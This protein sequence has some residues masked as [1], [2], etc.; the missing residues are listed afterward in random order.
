MFNTFVVKSLFKTCVV[1][2]TPIQKVEQNY[3]NR[4]LDE[5][6]THFVQMIFLKLSLHSH[7]YFYT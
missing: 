5:L 4:I 2:I 7:L 1:N 3:E 6:C